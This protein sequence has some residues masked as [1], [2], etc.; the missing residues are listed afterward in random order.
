MIF[1]P[2]RL[3]AA[4][5]VSAALLAPLAPLAPLPAAAAVA[6]PADA[7]TPATGADVS[8]PQCPVGMG[9]KGRET[10]GLPMPGAKATFVV[11]GVTNGPGFSRNPC[12]ASQVGW[13]RDHGV[14]TAAYSVVS[15]PT[16][17]QLRHFAHSGPFKGA[18]LRSQLRN[19]GYAQARRNLATMRTAGFSVPHIWLDVEIYPFRPWTSRLLNNRAVV[20]GA[21]RAYAQAGL[22]R[23]IYS[24]PSQFASIVGRPLWRLPEWHTAGPRGRST[25]LARCTERPFNGGRVVLSQWW[26]SS[27]DHDLTC[28]AFAGTAF[29]RYFRA[30]AG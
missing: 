24:T 30:A 7:G 23:G 28:P 16:R 26:T 22:S 5:S 8:W 11:I 4:L 17:W 20:R 12:L 2:H 29:Q 6:S 14:A 25:A 18:K 21:L 27:A 19:V 13:A 10:L 3:L 9:I 1:A 15:Y